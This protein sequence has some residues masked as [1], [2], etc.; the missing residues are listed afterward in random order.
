MFEDGL[1]YRDSRMAT[2]AEY[3][4]EL[5]PFCINDAQCVSKG[6][7]VLFRRQNMVFTDPSEYA[8]RKSVV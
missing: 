3:V 1:Y 5:A 7:P 8:D 4:Q 6:G 2:E